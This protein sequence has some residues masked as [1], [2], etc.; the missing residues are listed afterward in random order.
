MRHPLYHVQI[1]FLY[2]TV[3][4]KQ[5]RYLYNVHTQ[6]YSTKN[7]SPTLMKTAAS[8]AHSRPEGRAENRKDFKILS[9]LGFVT[10]FKRSR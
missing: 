10:L 5:Y 1:S 8:R 2:N 6:G 3:A 9:L 4:C 7:L